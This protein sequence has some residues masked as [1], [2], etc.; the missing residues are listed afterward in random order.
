[1]NL[2]KY[3]SFSM[4]VGIFIILDFKSLVVGNEIADIKLSSF[5]LFS[6]TCPV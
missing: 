4:I 1:M 6:F 2:L 3:R 5:L